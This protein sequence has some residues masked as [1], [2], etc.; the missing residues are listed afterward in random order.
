V[1]SIKKCIS[2][3][4]GYHLCIKINPPIDSNF[5]NFLQWLFGDDCRRVD[6]NRARIESGLLEWNKLFEEPYRRIKTIYRADGDESH[7]KPE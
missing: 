2:K 5:A 3:S 7:G 1:E 6:F 4:K